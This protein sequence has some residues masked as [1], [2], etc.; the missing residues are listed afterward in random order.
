M[1]ADATAFFFDF[2]E[3]RKFTPVWLGLVKPSKSVEAWA[4]GSAAVD[5]DISHADDGRGVHATGEL[6]EDRTVRAQA[7]LDGCGQDGAEV[8][9]VFGVGAVADALARIKVPIFANDVLSG[10]EDHGRGWRNSVDSNVGGQVRGGEIRREPAGD[11]LFADL[12]G[13][14]R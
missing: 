3:M 4:F 8:F 13:S 6:G 5:H 2:G 7:T 11:V 9:F 1:V 10:A 14:A 12:E